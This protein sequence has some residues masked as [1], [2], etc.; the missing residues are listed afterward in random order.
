MAQIAAHTLNIPITDVYIK[1]TCTDSVTNSSPT[2]ASMS[3]D[4]NGMAVLDACTQLVQRLTPLRKKNPNATMKEI[5][6]K[7]YFD[8]IDLS[9]HGHYKTPDLYFD[10]ETG[11]GQPYN[12]FNWGV[13]CSEVEVDCLTGDFKILRTDIVMDVGESLNPAIDIGQI[14]G[15]FV[16]GMGWCTMEEVVWSQAGALLSRGPGWYKVPGFLDIPLDLRVHL[17]KDAPN[18][19]AIHSSKGVGEPPFFLSCSVF[20]AIRKA[21]EAVREEV[22]EKEWMD[23][24]SPATCERIRM[25]MR[26]EF[27]REEKK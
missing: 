19:R 7:A 24:D 25:A 4:L 13:A 26:D 2:A 21:V 15:A 11:I 6:K 17:L 23:F 8:R 27:V 14:E 18:P 12:Y 20:F 9:A 10:W 22:G 3:S 5:A 1:G 16:Q